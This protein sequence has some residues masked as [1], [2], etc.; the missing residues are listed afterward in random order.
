MSLVRDGI[1]RDQ[2]EAVRV[3]S[4][5]ALDPELRGA[6]PLGAAQLASGRV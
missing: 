4:R 5:T 3:G 2:P 6:D 1:Q